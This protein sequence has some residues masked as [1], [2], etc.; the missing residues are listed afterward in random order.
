MGQLTA[1]S[2]RKGL[3]TEFVGQHVV[4]LDSVTSTNDVAKRLAREG[5]PEG[6]L[7]VAEEQTA[8][9]GR[10]G[11][12]WIAPA[13]S[14]LLI[15]VVFRPSFLPAGLPHLLMASGLA[16]ARAI[17]DS[18][19]LQV[20]LKWPNDILL[21]GRKTGGIL[22]EA[23][24]SGEMIDHVVVGIGLNVNLDLAQVPEIVAFATS[25]SEELGGRVSR[26]RVLHSLLGS[27]ERE[28]L[29]LQDGE[30]PYGRWV[31]RLGQLGQGVEIETPRGKESGILERV[32][33]DGTLFLRRADGT[34]VPIT[35]GDVT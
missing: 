25:M 14:S 21:G 28:Y 20:R 11:R 33:E 7:V 17:E 35:V 9:R 24:L 4:H 8:G 34:E 6:T 3:H 2:I 10:Q 16:A 32:G 1:E 27:M 31:A 13:G 22:I 18:T 12:R 26:L 30:S 29:L 5:A 15:S 19:G 23:A